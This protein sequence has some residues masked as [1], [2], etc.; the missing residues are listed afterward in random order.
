MDRKDIVIIVLVAVLVG[1]LVLTGYTVVQE[2]GMGGGGSSLAIG[3]LA[4]QCDY[5]FYTI[6]AIYYAKTCNEAGTRAYSDTIFTN[7]FDSIHSACP[8]TGCK[9]SF[10]PETF[11]I[12]STL[13]ITK[14]AFVFEGSGSGYNIDYSK[15]SSVTR[16][17]AA[18]D[19]AMMNFTGVGTLGDRLSGIVIRDILFEGV[20]GST[21]DGIWIDRTDVT[22][23]TNI[24]VR[25]F[26]RCLVFQNADAPIVTSS[27]FQNCG[28]GVVTLSGTSFPV[29]SNNIFADNTRYCFASNGGVSGRFT[30]NLVF[31]CG[32]GGTYAGAIALSTDKFIWANNNF[33]QN[34]GKGLD[35]AGATT[36]RNVVTGNVFGVLLTTTPTDG[37]LLYIGGGSN[38]TITGNFFVDDQVTPTTRYGI[39]EL[40]GSNDNLIMD[41]NLSGSYTNASVFISGTASIVKNNRGYVTENS[42]GTSVADGGTISHGLAGTPDT[43]L[44]TT[45]ITDEFCSVTALAVTTFTVT[46]TKHDGTAGTTQTIYWYAEFDPA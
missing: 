2:T 12:T 40:T 18:S 23:I 45:S 42:G 32:T 15:T 36:T 37:A 1:P 31:Q 7:V 3:S 13:T 14:Q 38:H 33:Q 41:N 34:R 43:V 30:G 26:D 27:S 35:L 20:S 17:L 29:I 46:I 21:R 8:S 9:L 39:Y 6:G 11:T 25:R 19:I 24:V 16:F 28:E 5:H 10:G 4:G 22:Q 44:C